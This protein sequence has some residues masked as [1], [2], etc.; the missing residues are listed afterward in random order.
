MLF[1][2]A[3]TS[4][5]EISMTKSHDDQKNDQKNRNMKEGKKDRIDMGKDNKAAGV[6]KQDCGC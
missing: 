6:K 2:C 3:E 1:D 5:K 4:E